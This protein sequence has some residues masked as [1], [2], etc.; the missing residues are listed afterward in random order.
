LILK[1]PKHRKM[2]NCSLFFKKCNYS[3]K[4][5]R[6]CLPRNARLHR[7]QVKLPQSYRRFQLLIT[8]CLVSLQLKMSSL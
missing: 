5:L 2:Q 6:S 1:R 3:L 8:K 4:K 7:K